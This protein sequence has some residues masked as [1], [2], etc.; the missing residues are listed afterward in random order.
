MSQQSTVR[1]DELLG[2]VSIPYRGGSMPGYLSLVDPGGPP[3]PTMIYTNGFGERCEDG[4]AVIGAAALRRG[5]NFLTY[6]GPGQGAMLRDG[7]VTMRPDWENVLGPVVDFASTIP[8]VDAGAIVHFGHGLGG[9]LVARYAAHDHR[10]AAIVCNDGMTTF[11]ASS[12]HIPEP[13][14]ELIED[15]RDDE[16]APLLDALMRQDPR[17]RRGLS[18]GQRVFGEGTAVEYVRRTADY[19]LTADDI[20]R[21][22]TPVLVLENRDD[23]SLPGQA[24]NFARAMTAPVHHVVVSGADV[25]CETVFDY[26]ATNVP[27]TRGWRGRLG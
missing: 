16:A 15:E 7:R 14:L 5:Y 6:D 8:E 25:V 4:Y 13:I 21:I 1:D 24:A 12:P 27:S 11:Y 18:T 26:L 17:M 3:R 22:S 19:T 2:A 23:A 20:R 9:Y 10:A